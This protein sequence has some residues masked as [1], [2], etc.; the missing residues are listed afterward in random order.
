MLQSTHFSYASSYPSA[1]LPSPPQSTDFSPSFFSSSFSCSF[2]KSSSHK[3]NLNQQWQTKQPTKNGNFLA[4]AAA[5]EVGG[6][7]PDDELDVQDRSGVSQE[8]GSQKLDASQYE[9]LL[10]G[11]EQVTSV[12]QEMITL[13]SGFPIFLFIFLCLFGC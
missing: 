9:A 11:G 4:L 5:Y 12:L 13:V 2:P 3:Q 8:Q 6:G 1:R 7:Y 10:K